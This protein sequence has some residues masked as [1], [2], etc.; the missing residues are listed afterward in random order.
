MIWSQFNHIGQFPAIFFDETNRL[1]DDRDRCSLYIHST[2]FLLHRKKCEV[3]ILHLSALR[4]RENFS[5]GLIYT[6]Y[7]LTFNRSKHG[8]FTHGN[9]SSIHFN[10]NIY[11]ND[12]LFSN[13]EP[14]N[15]N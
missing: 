4:N 7:S 10:S 9:T 15:H 3:L 2:D 12:I 13:Y 6:A 11:L 8:N 14:T 5:Q 1:F